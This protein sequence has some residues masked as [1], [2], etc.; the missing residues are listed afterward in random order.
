MSVPG[1]WAVACP[2]C[3]AAIEVAVRDI[4]IRKRAVGVEV[5]AVAVNYAHTCR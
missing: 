5:D 4:T 2:A 3:D 1:I